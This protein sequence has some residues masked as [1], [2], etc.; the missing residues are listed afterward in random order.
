MLQ[1]SVC[2]HGPWQPPPGGPPASLQRSRNPPLQG[3]WQR[4]QGP[5]GLHWHE[6][7]EI[8]L[9]SVPRPT[10]LPPASCSSMAEVPCPGPANSQDNDAN[11]VAPPPP[12][13]R[14][15]PIA[16]AGSRVWTEALLA[17]WH[18][19]EVWVPGPRPP[20]LRVQT[21]AVAVLLRSQHG[22]RGWGEASWIPGPVLLQGS[23]GGSGQQA[24]GQ[25]GPTG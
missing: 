15:L 6:S 4:L 23:P 21:E 11:K 2:A 17:E 22:G 1:L 5:Q 18:S 9:K 12:H 8:K 3:T 10:C 13:S 25:A 20:C 16:L 24:G 14:P 19:A 7:G